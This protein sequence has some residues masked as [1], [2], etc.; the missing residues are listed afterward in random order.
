MSESE[1][2]RMDPLINK[3]KE[4]DREDEEEDREDEVEYPDSDEEETP[5]SVSVSPSGVYLRLGDIILFLAPQNPDLH[6]NTFF[7]EYIDSKYISLIR[8]DTLQRYP[9]NITEDGTLTDETIREIDILSRAEEEGYARQNGLVPGIWV[10]LHIE[11]TVHVTITGEITDIQEDQIQITT[12]PDMKVIYVNFDYKGIPKHIP[13]EKIVIR[14]KPVE[15]ENIGSLKDIHGLG[16]DEIEDMQ[17]RE[18]DISIEYLDNGE[19]IIHGISN[20]GEERDFRDRLH[21]LYRSSE[22]IVFL[23]DL[24]DVVQLVELPE[25]L[26]R[27]SVEVQV[28]SIVDEMLSTIPN[29][30]RTKSVMDRIHLLVERYKELR[31]IFSKFDE[32]DNIRSFK[33][34]DPTYKPLVERLSELDTRLKWIIPVVE[35]H[36]KL[37]DIEGGDEDEYLDTGIILD[38]DT[39]TMNRVYYEN[40]SSEANRYSTLYQSMADSMT[41]FIPLPDSH[42]YLVNRPVKT[43]LEAIISNTEDFYS[44]TVH[45]ANTIMRRFVIETY[46]LGLSNLDTV[47]ASD[48]DQMTNSTW[49]RCTEGGKRTTVRKEMTSADKMPIKSFLVLPKPVMHYSKLYLPSTNILDRTNLHQTDFMLFRL[50]RKNLKNTG[51]IQHIIDDLDKEVDYETT[52][53]ETGIGFLSK[54]TEYVL[55]DSMEAEPNKFY[56]F[57]STIFPKTKVLLR[58]IQSQLKGKLSVATVMDALE[59]FLIYSDD[60]TYGHYANE[61]RYF[62]K[63]RIASL[64]LELLERAKPFKSYNDYKF[65]IDSN[66]KPIL[67]ILKDKPE[68]FD[69]FISLYDIKERDGGIFTTNEITKQIQEFD[70]NALF[71][72]LLSTMMISL[73]TPESLTILREGKLDEGDIEF[74]DNLDKVKATDCSQKVITKLYD[75]MEALMKDNHNDDL[76]YDREYDSTPYSIFKKYEDQ[77]KKMAPD[78]FLEFLEENLVQKHD[79]PREMA[80]GLART[81]IEGKKRVKDGEYAVV[82][83]KPKESEQSVI[84][85]EADNEKLESE[86]DARKK[87]Y[88]FQRKKTVWVQDKDAD[89]TMFIDSSVILCN[90]AKRC[91]IKQSKLGDECESITDTKARLMEDA[92]KKAIKEFDRRYQVS[93][94]DLKTRLEKQLKEQLRFTQR[95]SLLKDIQLKRANILEYEYGKG[96]QLEEIIR[97]PY[98]NLLNLILEQDDFA[99]KQLDIIRFTAKFTRDPIRVFRD[100]SLESEDEYWRYCKETNVKLIPDFLVILAQEFCNG[101]DYN[102]KLDELCTPDRV[103]VVGNRIIDIHSGRTMR[104]LDFSTEEGY[105]DAGFRISTNAVLEIN[106]LE[107]LASI[108]ISISDTDLREFKDPT[109]EI[110]YNICAAICKNIDIPITSVEES[111]LRIANDMIQDKQIVSS[112]EAHSKRAAKQEKKQGKKIAPYNEYRNEMIIIITV[113]VLLSVIQSIQGLK[114]NK[115]FPGCVRSFSGYPFGGIEDLTTIEYFACVLE[116]MRNP[117]IIPWNSIFKVNRQGLKDRIKTICD[118]AVIKNAEIISLFHEKHEYLNLYPELDFIPSALQ[119]GRWKQFLPPIGNIDIIK[120]L[121]P[122]SQ[123][124][125]NDFMELLK[126]GN[127]SQT[128][129][130]LVLKSKIIQ[131]TFGLIESVQEVVDSKTV[132]LKTMNNI[133][134]LQNACCNESETTVNPMQYFMKENESIEQFMKTMGSIIKTVD[135]VKHISKAGAMFDPRRT[136]LHLLSEQQFESDQEN[137]YAAFIHYCGL[138]KSGFIPSDFHAFFTEV[139]ESYNKRASLAEKIVLLKKEGKQFGKGDLSDLMTVVRNKNIIEKYKSQR[140]TFVGILR[141]ILEGFD[142]TDSSI[143]EEP[144]RRHLEECLDDYS[145]TRLRAIEPQ[146]PQQ[147]LEDLKNYL[148]DTNERMYVEIVNFIRDFGKPKDKKMRNIMDFLQTKRTMCDDPIRKPSIQSWKLDCEMEN[149]GTYYDNGLYTIFNFMKQSIHQMT[150]IFPEIILNGVNFSNIPDHWKLGKNDVLFL[151]KKVEGHLESLCEFKEDAMITRVLQE[152]RLRNVDLFLFLSNLPVHTPIVKDGVTYYSIFD[153]RAILQIITY[154][155]YSVLHEYIIL[156]ND[157]DMLR[158]DRVEMLSERR[159]QRGERIDPQG[160]LFSE[161]VGLLSRENEELTD[162]YNDLMDVQIIAGQREDLKTRIAKLMMTYID[163]IQKNKVL[164]DYS[165]D[166]IAADVRSS[167]MKEKNMIIE[168]LKKLTPEERRVEN[169]MKVYKIGKWNVGQQRGLF[170][171]DIATQERERQDLLEQGVQDNEELYNIAMGELNQDVTVDAADINQIQ[172]EDDAQAAIDDHNEMFDFGNLGQNY[173]DGYDPDGYAEEEDFEDT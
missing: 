93:L 59:P 77:Q 5:K 166:E 22:G 123:T 127:K 135:Y 173:D 156:A 153:K 47:F 30:K 129:D 150:H 82:I 149:T 155:F 161:G 159:S 137:I 154:V 2:E 35:N 17:A 6:E 21:D 7:I 118:L 86:A 23:E 92:R 119:L 115:T 78:K 139:P 43:N 28:N 144:L 172:S 165:Y 67:R 41:P 58:F 83:I 110:I 128:D 168:R 140:Y 68:L 100:D 46:N 14:E 64:K 138:D 31:S 101:G 40:R 130:L 124:F 19:S 44:T 37:Y 89:E 171:Y 97:S 84:E 69:R 160:G 121:Q 32:N 133:P 9:L 70:Q 72:T 34:K 53:K 4:E 136:G 157:D 87:T 145:P 90:M 158:M 106:P 96:L 81:M 60:I 63:T 114:S 73:R 80:P 104:L 102:K 57:L 88:Y 27:Y 99:K 1:E 11:A 61:I 111:V 75:S 24:E 103:A 25:H 116:K 54:T 109:I 74:M 142:R 112:E 169:M 18:E 91:S 20:R 151:F 125:R 12:Y 167:K 126:T 13:F 33:I 16:K 48:E 141:D 71:T 113:S 66:S 95:L 38:A 117:S 55:D 39:Q 98:E 79:C 163:I 8:L 143:I 148:A 132:L 29:Q 36:K 134:F 170:E 162:P 56:R 52:D 49:R 94:E 108:G 120:H 76:F 131:H 45:K 42:E 107:N 105:N 26:Q 51:L 62:I 152:I 65:N 146:H 122:V 10:E 50:L 164:V 3:E 85:S 147:Q 15:L